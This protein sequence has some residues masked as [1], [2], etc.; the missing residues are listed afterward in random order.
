[1]DNKEQLTFEAG[2]FGGH[3][4]RS[5]SRPTAEAAGQIRNTRGDRAPKPGRQMSQK[6]LTTI[7]APL[8]IASVATMM[9]CAREGHE[10]LIGLWCSIVVIGFVVV[11]FLGNRPY[12]SG[13]WV[14]DE[15]KARV[16]ALLSNLRL[17]VYAY[18]WGALA[19]HGLYATRLTGLR[20]QHGWQYGTAMT[21]LAAITFAYARAVWR[22]QGDRQTVWLRLAAPLAVFQCVF[23]AGSLLFL[24]SSGKLLTRRADF[25]A[26]QIF[27][28]LALMVMLLAAFALRTHTRLSARE[29][30]VLS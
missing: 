3:P 6:S 24:A 13:R 14:V 2:V 27:L 28:S 21:L 25:A 11:A 26:N 5:H 4:K 12:W 9:L 29:Q 30:N 23:A 20:W 17:L 10:A 22:S 15:P 1:M 7:L 16:S 19:M 18:A 8:L